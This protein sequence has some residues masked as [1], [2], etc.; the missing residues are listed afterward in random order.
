[1]VGVGAIDHVV[2]RVGGSGVVDLFDGF[3]QGLA[4]GQ[5]AVGFHGEGDDHGQSRLARGEDDAQGFVHVVHGQ[6]GDHVDGGLGE[7]AD[8]LAVVTLRLELVH[9]LVSD[10]TIAAR[11]DA[12]A[13][14][15]R[16]T[17]AF[18]FTAQFLQQGDGISIGL[19]Q[20]LG[21]EAEVAGPVGIG[22]PGRT[23]Q[24]QPGAVMAGQG[25]V[26]AEVLAQGFLAVSVVEQHESREIRKGN[27][28]MEDQG[29]L[30][31]TV[32]EEQFALQLWQGTAI[33][34]HGVTP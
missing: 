15:H 3:I 26:G 22:A 16:G 32:G 11:A 27:P 5:P 8:L 23:F 1:M 28:L 31:A 10:I 20:A 24:D 9:G 12:A 34:G 21:G 19:G 4:G 17:A 13:D 30:D 25:A 14:H 33:L 7:Y 18:H 29:G 2:G 6:G